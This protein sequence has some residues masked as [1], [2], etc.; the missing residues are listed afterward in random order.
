MDAHQRAL[1]VSR[2][3]T[4]RGPSNPWCVGLPDPDVQLPHP[5]AHTSDR[6][7]LGQLIDSPHRTAPWLRV[8]AHVESP[9]SETKSGAL[10]T[11]S[12]AWS[13]RAA[14]SAGQDRMSSRT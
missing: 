1:A 5:S 3:A 12:H 7:A 13:A 14:R 9:D 2:T 6:S 11:V 8:R 4:A 10:K